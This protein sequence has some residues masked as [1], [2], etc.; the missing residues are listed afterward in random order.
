MKKRGG[1]WLD[2]GLRQRVEQVRLWWRPQAETTATHE[3]DVY[4]NVE[5]VRVC[6]DTPEEMQWRFPACCCC[7]IPSVSN[8]FQFLVSTSC[9]SVDIAAVALELQQLYRQASIAH[10]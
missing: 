10:I 7:L 1:D 9:K 3:S 5:P 4:M 6:T 2:P 8:C